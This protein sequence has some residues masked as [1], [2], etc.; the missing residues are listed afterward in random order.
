MTDVWIRE[1]TGPESVARRP[2]AGGADYLH[3][4]CSSRSSR[5][6]FAEVDLRRLA[7]AV[8]QL[9]DACLR[10]VLSPDDYEDIIASALQRRGWTLIKSLCFRSKTRF[11][12]QMVRCAGGRRRI[13]Y[14]QVKSGEVSLNPAEYSTETEDG[15]VV[16]LF[17][18]ASHP[19]ASSRQP[20]VR[21]IS[22][23]QMREWLYEG[24]FT[25]T[26]SL[27]LRLLLVARLQ[28][29]SP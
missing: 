4:T 26:P 10:S 7:A 18:S 11:E 17:S 2:L 21:P 8:R 9:D 15:A 27:A 14:C 12:F 20:G 19:Y 23:R 28:T 5:S 3:R 29:G 13:A 25:L 16:Y 24:L 6:L 1:T 22:F